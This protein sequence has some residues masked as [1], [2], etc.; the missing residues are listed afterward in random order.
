MKNSKFWKVLT[1]LG[2]GAMMTAS[3]FGMAACDPDTG[4]TGDDDDNGGGHKHEYV[5]VSDGAS[6]HHQECK[7]HDDSKPKEAH[8]YDNDDDATCNKCDYVREIVTPPV[9]TVTGVTV[10]SGNGSH[11]VYQ[12]KT[13]Q[14]TA[15]VTGTNNPSQAVTWQ[16]SAVETA[17]V[18]DEGL[19]T[20]VAAGQVTI[21]ATSKLD[22]TKSAEYTLTVKE[23]P[24]T[25]SNESEKA[26]VPEYTGMAKGPEAGEHSVSYNL[27]GAS[28]TEA[29]LSEAYSDGIFS[30]PANTEFRN[31]TP[32]GGDNPK[33]Y[34]RSIKNGTITVNVPSAGTLKINF[35]SGSSKVGDAKY[36]LT[37]NG[38]AQPVVVVQLA[39]KVLT[40]VELEVK[41]GDVVVFAKA[42]GTI[43]TYEVELALAPIAAK[44]IVSLELVSA[45]ISDYLITQKVDCTGVQLVAKDG[46]GVTHEVALENCHFDTSNYNPDAS[47]EYTIG[48]TYYL[49]DNLDSDV[50]EFQASYKVKVYAVDSIKLDLIGLNGSSQV[51]VQQAYLTTDTYAKDNYI[52]VIATCEYNG[53]TLEYKLKKDWFSLT[54]TIDLTTAGTKTVEVAVDTKY[55][56]GNKEVKASY[57]IISA[58]KKSVENGKVTVTVGSSGEF[59]SVTQ[60]VQYLKKCDYDASVIKVIEIAAGTYTEKVWIDVA[61]VTLIGKGSDKNDTKISYSLVEGDADNYSGALWG[62]N[63]AT[64]HVTGANFKAYNLSIH[65]DFDYI[66]NSG[67][68]SGSQAAQG[69][70][71]TLDADGAVLY[72]CHLYGNQDTLYFKSGRSY[73]YKTQIDGNIDFIFGGETGLAFFEECKIVAIGRNKNDQTGYV[74]AAQH[75]EGTKPDYGYIFYKCE[76]T[77]DGNV[78]A[79]TMALG[80]P[81]G[82]KATIAYIECSFSKAYSTKGYGDDSVKMHR[83]E[84]M[85]GAKPADADFCEYG[86]TGDGAIT[87]AVAGG[88]ILTEE[89]AA[90]YTKANIFAV[91]NGKQT[92][93][94]TVFDCDTAYATLRILAGLDA[95]E[96]PKDTTV[97]VSLTETTIPDG[98]C[99]EYINTTYADVLTWEGTCWIQAS[100]PENG[101]KIG[102]D[103]V[104]KIKIVGEVALVAGYELPATDYEIIYKDGMATIKFVA[105]TGQFG[106]FIGSII[107]DTSKTVP[108][109]EYVVVTLDYNDGTT[110]NSTISV[111]KGSKLTQPADPVRSGY[112]FEYWYLDGNES[113]AYDFDNTVVNQA[114]TLK[115]KW[116]AGE[117]ATEY[118]AGAIIEIA[119]ITQT[120]QAG[121]STVTGLEQGV[122]LDA[123][124]GKIQ[125]NGDNVLFN[126]GAIIKVKVAEG[127]TVLPVWHK[128]TPK[129]GFTVSERDS[130]GYVTITGV[131]SSTYIMKIMVVSVYSVE[132]GGTLACGKGGMAASFQGHYASNGIIEIDAT[133]SGAKFDGKPDNNYAQFNMGTVIKIKAPAGV[134]GTDGVTVTI[135]AYNGT[136][137]T[138]KYTLGYEDGYITLT[139]TSNSNPDCYPS[140]FVISYAA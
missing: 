24:G 48:V 62:L 49:E 111:I 15:V 115:A 82:A 12:G 34:T 35:A 52:S 112:T 100:K 57:E 91:K 60:A 64:V 37:V 39:S 47:G 66:A 121:T 95:G 134:T 29:T 107:I 22:D 133:A 75:K 26:I 127:L 4:N 56:V 25:P 116:T 83:W 32:N 124:A 59:K 123:T 122:L 101:I 51:T 41:Q 1:A 81:W 36:Q 135:T 5:Y 70:A 92:R 129:D 55:T 118:E 13:L 42:G 114:I 8:V 97:T 117:V 69:V 84:D 33:G 43:D 17:I 104:I 27:L 105:A 58:A 45:G 16:S 85:S 90:N 131:G 102:T 11:S 30:L 9:A 38:T 109:T 67:N 63:C 50:T 89:Q 130:N 44:P 106:T 93:Y 19:V 96:L 87:T 72:N 86:S 46:N 10:T 61:N 68:Y 73:Y 31:Q 137:I 74:T 3:V 21:T 79:G 20:G 132:N 40:S 88:K 140:T 7:D 138:D 6:G 80:R 28:F 94:S 76:L 113:E 128:L 125:P 98:N 119:Q 110:A 14:L 2:M 77:D 120:Y 103:T 78:P 71:L 136:D 23:L 54:E 108:D 18:S 139:G 53:D 99:L 65:N 126:G